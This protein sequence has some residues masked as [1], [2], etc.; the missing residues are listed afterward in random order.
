MLKPNKSP[1]FCYKRRSLTRPKNQRRKT[2]VNSCKDPREELMKI[3]ES[4][5]EFYTQRKGKKKE[6]YYSKDKYNTEREEHDLNREKNMEE[7]K[8]KEGCRYN[9]NIHYNNN[10]SCRISKTPMNFDCTKPVYNLD[11]VENL[12]RRIS[13]CN[14][15][16][17]FKEMTITPS[18][19][20]NQTNCT[21]FISDD[22]YRPLN[23][24]LRPEKRTYEIK[25]EYDK[26][27]Y[28][29]NNRFNSNYL[30]T[31]DIASELQNSSLKTES[32]MKNAIENYTKNI[33]DFN[34]LLDISRSSK[35]KNDLAGDSL[36]KY[37]VE[38]SQRLKD[39]ETMREFLLS[40]EQRTS[41][42]FAA[43]IED[44]KN[45]RE[46]K[47]ME[48]RQLK[49]IIKE[50]NEKIHKNL[51]Y[52]NN[53]M[54]ILEQ[55]KA[56]ILERIKT[57][58]ISSMNSSRKEAKNISYN[59]CNNII[60][61]NINLNRKKLVEKDNLGEGEFFYEYKSNEVEGGNK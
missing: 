7:S 20:R 10:D 58:G 11:D 6:S 28:L 30:T 29:N 12:N 50:E 51:E 37:R 38:N 45:E 53:K 56:S 26:N 34:R 19:Q 22:Y 31:L 44:E 32:I 1:K 9:K 4:L 60:N 49:S 47:R 52:F 57:F 42:R 18:M 46:R 36:L 21:D 59:N 33:D 41:E 15:K 14:F 24:T 48:E 55:K 61:Y 40:M 27:F 16:N 54:R 8:G 35:E 5:N 13:G 2:S 17:D 39:L 23:N 43:K 25:S 3:R